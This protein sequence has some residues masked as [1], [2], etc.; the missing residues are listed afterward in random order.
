MKRLAYRA[1]VETARMR[2][3]LT[4]ESLAA[5]LDP[6]AGLEAEALAELEEAVARIDLVVEKLD[7]AAARLR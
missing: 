3:D 6:E 4:R 1:V 7:A 2:I 5:L